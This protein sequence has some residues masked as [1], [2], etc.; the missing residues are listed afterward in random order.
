MSGDCLKIYYQNVRGLNTNATKVRH[1]I[2]NNYYDIYIFTETWLSSGVFD[3]EIFE[4]G[5]NVYRRD[6]ETSSLSSKVGGGGVLIAV[7]NRFISTRLTDYE[8]EGEDLWV[9]VTSKYQGRP[10]SVNICA[11]YLPPP[12]NNNSLN[13]FIDKCNTILQSHCDCDY[14]LIAGDFN[15]GGITWQRSNDD[16]NLSLIPSDYGNSELVCKLIDFLVLNDLRQFNAINNKKDKILD[17]ILC[18]QDVLNIKECLQPV[19]DVDTHHPALEIKMNIKTETFKKSIHIKRHNFYKADYKAINTYLESVNWTEELGSCID[20]NQSVTRFYEII[21]NVIKKHVPMTQS[22]PGSYPIWFSNQLIHMFKLK[23][24]YHKKYKKYKNPLDKLEYEYLRND[25]NKQIKECYNKYIYTIENDIKRNPKRFWSHVKNLRRNC[26]SY[27]DT[28]TL[29]NVSTSDT[30][31]I[32]DLF[33]THFSSVYEVDNNKHT[34]SKTSMP[35]DKQI[36]NSIK[37]SPD[38]I[39]KSLKKLDITKSAGPDN[40]HPILLVNC[41]NA[42]SLPLSILYNRSLETGIFPDT[43]KIARVVPIHK[44]GKREWIVNYRPVSVLSTVSKVFESL[45]YSLIC[46]QVHKYISDEQSGFM[47]KRSTNT[48]LMLF[49]SDIIEKVDQGLQVDA[50]YTDFSKAFDK[51]NHNILLEKLHLYGVPDGLLRWCDS[52]LRGRA[53]V[54]VVDGY[55]SSPFTA[56]SGVPQG[57]VLGPL[58]FN[59][60]INDIIETVKHSKIYLFADDLKLTKT[61]SNLKDSNELQE[62]V[63]SLQKWCDKN[64]MFLNA[65]KCHHIKFTKKRIGFQSDYRISGNKLEEVTTIRDL[66]VLIDSKLRF[67]YHIDRAVKEANRAL[68][69]VLRN[70]KCFRKPSTIILLYNSYVRSKLEYCSSVWCPSYNVHIKRIERVQK[71]LISNLTYRFNAPLSQK[72]YSDKAKYFHLEPLSVR[73]IIMDMSNLYKLMNGWIDSPML[74]NQFNFNVPQRLPRHPCTLFKTK[75]C[76]TKLGQ[77]SPVVRL[78]RLYNEFSSKMPKLDIHSQSLHGFLSI[79]REC[80][81]S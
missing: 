38:V 7:S 73:R 55:Q 22:R 47:A 70:T 56:D 75:F 31:H 63:D 41:A 16:R 61:V 58:F 72:T 34:Y 54:V 26:S 48:N 36:N 32:A 64:K 69:F 62:D 33:A 14:T 74:L 15:M 4:N 11:V 3:C 20:I 29:A 77:D 79:I 42:L 68:G 8:S 50:V 2:I 28:M 45:V 76:R 44:N 24:K 27:P 23:N 25:C 65:A 46:T 59:V 57:S 78:S 49:V 10:I 6:R 66:G 30:K 53:S 18:D 1:Q 60:F 51:V 12:M 9:S 43:W 67:T 81:L 40:I 13:I 39:M 80:D 19:R 5:Y 52:Y 21:E 71:K 17:L 35:N 37:F